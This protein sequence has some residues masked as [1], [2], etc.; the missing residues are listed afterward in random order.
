MGDIRSETPPCKRR[1][2]MKST[3]EGRRRSEGRDKGK[4]RERKREKEG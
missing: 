1:G 4:G 2:E 3:V